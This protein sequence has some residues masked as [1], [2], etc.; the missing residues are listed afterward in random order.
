MQVGQMAQPR[1]ALHEPP[2]FEG[3]ANKRM[4]Q[5]RR[6][7]ASCDNHVVIDCSNAKRETSRD[8]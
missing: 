7:S 2:Q 4:A 3:N 5:R 8:F 1:I 6:I